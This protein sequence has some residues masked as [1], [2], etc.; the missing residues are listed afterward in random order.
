MASLH[1]HEIDGKHQAAEGCEM[2]PVQRLVTEEQGRKD[3][4]D[5]QGDDFLDDLQLHQGVRA[6][7]AD[8]AYAV[9]GHLTAVLKKGDEP[10]ESDDHKQGP[11]GTD[12]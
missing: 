3:G 2:V 1:K 5:G 6:T 7:V 12:P 4:E 11:V 8:E 9:G 10:R